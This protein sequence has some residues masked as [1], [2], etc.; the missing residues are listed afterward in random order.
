MTTRR[1][2]LVSPGFT[3]G[4]LFATVFALALLACGPAAAPATPVTQAE[5][6]PTLEPEATPDPD[7]PKPTWIPPTPLPFKTPVPEPPDTSRAAH[8]DGIE[9]CKALSTFGVEDTNARDYVDWCSD[10]LR[11]QVNTTC[12]P[13][14]TLE[15]QR[16]CGDDIVA[17][18]RLA[19][20]RYGP[21]CS[22]LT[23]E[24]SPVASDTPPSGAHPSTV[25]LQEMTD[26]GLKAIFAMYEAWTKVRIGGDRDPAVVEAMKDV[27]T[28]LEEKGYK[29]VDPE[30]LFVWQRLGGGTEKEQQYMSVLTPE[31]RKL[32]EE[33]MEPARD[34]GKMHGL[35]EAQ[36]AAWAE[37]LRRLDKEEPATVEHLIREGLL[38]ALE[39]PGTAK[40]LID[41]LPHHRDGR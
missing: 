41:F 17:E 7:N 11:T 5:P 32:G 6:T 22:G 19:T 31:A 36:D 27:D 28:C 34:C 18:Y 39:K 8:P 20:L 10:Q 13:L 3:F 25:C 33:L 24:V 9:G 16:R 23:E 30:L 37:E 4:F 1:L 40:L 15:A 29:D 12:R 21:Q 14:E 2:P 38:E 26:E 35:F